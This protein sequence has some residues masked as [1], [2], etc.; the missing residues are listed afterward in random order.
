MTQGYK[1]ETYIQKHNINIHS[2]EY[3]E[4]KMHALSYNSLTLTFLT[5][6]ITTCLIFF[7]LRALG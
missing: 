7:T 6:I 4:I 2:H 3:E 5:F 1:I